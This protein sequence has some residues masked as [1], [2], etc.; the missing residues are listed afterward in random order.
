MQVRFVARH[1]RFVIAA[2]LT[3]SAS[4]SD[5]RHA[6]GSQLHRPGLLVVRVRLL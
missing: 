1:S 4:N 5:F 6:D 2:R 3:R